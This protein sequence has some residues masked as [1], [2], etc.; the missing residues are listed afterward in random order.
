MSSNIL[1]K[2]EIFSLLLVHGGLN[3]PV[4]LTRERR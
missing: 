1:F 2:F 4:V 3:R